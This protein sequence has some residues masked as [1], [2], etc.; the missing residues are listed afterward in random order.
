MPTFSLIHTTARV[1]DGWKAA[2]SSWFKNCDNPQDVEYILC[3]D[4][5]CSYPEMATQLPPFGKVDFI[6]NNGRPCPVDGWNA[7]AAASTGKFIITVADD[8]YPCDHWD[9][10]LQLVIPD[11]DEEYVLDLNTTQFRKDDLLT[12]SCLTRKYY[13]RYGYVFYPEYLGLYAD[14]EFTSQAHRDGVVIKARQLY[15][16]HKHFAYNT[17]QYDEVYKLQNDSD[18][19]RIGKEIYERRVREGVFENWR[20]A[21]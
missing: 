2:A 16:E 10:Q 6:L 5:P 8:W 15:F 12:F 4:A 11:M 21:A 7:A 13:E 1:P 18:R 14:D 9:T 19:G 20:K 3:V 17:A